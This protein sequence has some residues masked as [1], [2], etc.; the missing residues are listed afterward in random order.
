M[1]NLKFLVSNPV[2]IADSLGK[3]GASKLVPVLDEVVKLDESRREGLQKVEALKARRNQ[4]SLEIAKQKKEKKEDNTLLDQMKL[5]AKEIKEL[6]EKLGEIDAK[7][8]QL[9][10]EF[11]NILDAAVPTGKSSEDN[12]VVKS[13]GEAPRFDYPVKTH[14]EIGETMGILNFKKAGEVSGA[15]FVFLKG[16][17]A[18]LE[19]ALVQFM[20]STHGKEGYEELLPPFLVN[21]Q[22][23]IGTGQ[24]PKFEEDV[25]RI[26]KFDY[27][28]IPTAEV[29]VT[30]YHRNEI[31]E[32]KD[33]PIRYMAYTPCFRSEAGSY[34]KDTKGLKRQHQFDKV[35]LVK[36]TTP[37]QSAQEHERLLANAEKILQLLGLHYRV[38]LLCGGDIGFSSSKT[39]DIEVW[40]PASQS[41]M[42]ISSCSNFTDFQARRA[43]IRYRSAATGKVHFVHTLNGSGLAVGRTLIAIMENYQT[44]QGTFEIPPALQPFLH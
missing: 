35:E 32:E 23:L 37:E 7:M 30:N 21:R 31:L 44:K 6:D 12:K 14:D 11:P 20:L 24:L 27:F 26:E 41:Y 1:L 10:F 13:W 22:S 3:R 39:Y 8:N 34:G 29:P 15:R 16:L 28:L 36:F 17:A 43:N 5:V 19:H 33:L 18:R 9:M 4:A 38:V 2:V 40:S 25:F 42:E